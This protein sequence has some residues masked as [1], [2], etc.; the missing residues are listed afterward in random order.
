MR[1]VVGAP[2]ARVRGFRWQPA[3]VLNATTQSKAGAVGGILQVNL[4]AASDDD[5]YCGATTADNSQSSSEQRS[6]SI[7]VRS[8]A[9]L[10]E[11]LHHLL[12]VSSP[13][14]SR[15]RQQN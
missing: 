6:V 1:T 7:A 11:L 15:R 2:L 12:C 14:L 10:G 4:L 9:T 5:D 13:S 8:H 3:C